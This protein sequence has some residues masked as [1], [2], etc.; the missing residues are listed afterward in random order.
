MMARMDTHEKESNRQNTG[1]SARRRRRRALRRRQRRR[2]I[3][4]RRCLLAV[5]ILS[6]VF[7]LVRCGAGKR[8]SA[9]SAGTLS[10]SGSGTREETGSGAADGNIGESA[11]SSGNGAAVGETGDAGGAQGSSSESGGTADRASAAASDGTTAAVSDGTAAVS[12]DGTGAPEIPKL[13]SG[14]AP[15]RTGA[16]QTI[17][18]TQDMQS[19]YAVLINGAT[20]EI[21]AGFNEDTRI[22]P[23]SMT[24]ILTLLTAVKEIEKKGQNADGTYAA[25]DDPFTI[26]IEITD[27]AYQNGGSSTGFA[28]GE[29]VPVRDL[30]YGTIL[31]SGADSAAGLAIYTAGSQE[32]FVDLMNQ[33]LQELGLSGTSHFTNCV[34]FY[35]PEHYSTPSDM[36]MI[37][38]AA[39]EDP[40]CRKV[41]STHQ[42]TTTATEQHPEGIALSN[43]FL[44]RIEDKDT[45][46]T[47]LCAKTGYV[48]E[49]RNCA[50]SFEVSDSGTPYFCVTADAHSAWRCIYDQVTIYSTYVN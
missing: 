15:K 8:N 26:T 24:K 14:Y 35:D 47:V 18:Q 41:L 49:S 27:F 22:V 6:A 11:G 40:L 46:G 12:A 32:A 16:E 31:P 10:E 30:L 28:V 19:N 17:A 50:A 2:R 13:F 23:A 43:W 4:I 20:G 38:K 9:N 45:H 42:Y 25:V 21:T 36:A 48:K 5:L 29:T 37:L 33:E 39:V 7:L 44:R 1:D 34:G 3:L